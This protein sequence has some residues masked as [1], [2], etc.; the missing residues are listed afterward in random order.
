M[1][2]E[3]KD[4]AADTNAEV[5]EDTNIPKEEDNTSDD[6]NEEAVALKEKLDSALK[7]KSELTARAKK[8]EEEL[9]TLK[10]NPQN[11]PNDPQLSEEL[12]LIARG[13]SDEEIE[14]A[15][16]IAKGKGIPLPEAI[17]DPLFTVFQRDLKEREKK[18]KAKLG[19]SKGSGE[20]EDKPLVRS[21]M[22]REEHE[23]VFK[24]VLG[25]K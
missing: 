1:E 9:K 10:A 3:T 18:E 13:L 24:E 23:K 7:A 2:E 17:K 12:K 4:V 22:S 21:G 11:K 16:V 5:E 8:A 25:K 6:S 14:Q 19:A 20:S 15:K